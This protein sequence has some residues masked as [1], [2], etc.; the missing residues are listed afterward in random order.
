MSRSFFVVIRPFRRGS[1]KSPSHPSSCSFPHSSTIL[2]NYV[3]VCIQD[4]SLGLP[5]SYAGSCSL[6]SP[7]RL[8]VLDSVFAKKSSSPLVAQPPPSEAF[9]HPHPTFFLFRPARLLDS[10]SSF[11]TFF[12]LIASS[13]KGSH[14]P[15]FFLTLLPDLGKE[16]L[17]RVPPGLFDVL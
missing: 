4:S 7:L 1:W 15:F 8:L 16:S 13:K 9:C 12:F 2:L 14:V 17:G 11:Y 5:G 6:N 10:Y 3:Q